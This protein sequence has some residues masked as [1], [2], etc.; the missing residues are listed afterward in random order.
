MQEPAWRTTVFVAGQRS[1]VRVSSWNRCICS[2]HKRRPFFCVRSALNFRSAATAKPRVKPIKYRVLDDQDDDRNPSAMKLLSRAQPNFNMQ[3]AIEGSSPQRKGLSVKPRNAIN[4]PLIKAL[5]AN[6]YGLLALATM[7]SAL[8]LLISQGPGAF[9]HLDDIVKWSGGGSGLFDFQVT[10]D[11]LL[12]GIGGALPMLAFS[13]WIENSDK[14]AF[15]NLNF[16]TIVLCLSLFGRRSV[17]P[18]DFL[19][20]KYRL[21]GVNVQLP[22]TKN[23]EALVE[24]LT[25]ST[26]TGF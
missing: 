13:N 3:G 16:S 23:W 8:V 12:L 18:N 24:S 7:F 20:P 25:L 14:R 21:E 19:P 26:V 10:T 22:K 11:A 4:K 17:P 6:Q 1:H 9:S 5:Q 2:N 15:F